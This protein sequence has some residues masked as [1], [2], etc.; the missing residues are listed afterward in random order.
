[1]RFPRSPAFAA[2]LLLI[3]HRMPAQNRREVILRLREDVSTATAHVSLNEMQTLKLDRCRQTLLMA[4]QSGSV[5]KAA[6]GKDLDGA[7]RDIEKYFQK[8]LFL[9]EDRDAVRQ[10]ISQLRAIERRQRARRP[11]RR[12]P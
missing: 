12:S 1:M 8:D 3:A 7:L 11:V 2:T 6:S 4:A 10:D 5:D 9:Q